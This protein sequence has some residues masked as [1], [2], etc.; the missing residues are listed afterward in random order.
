MNLLASRHDDPA[1][2]RGCTL[3]S[4]LALMMLSTI[5]KLLPPLTWIVSL[6]ESSA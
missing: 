6:I 3:V 1:K 2:P 4:P 5:C